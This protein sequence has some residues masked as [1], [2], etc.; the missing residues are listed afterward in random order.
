MSVRNQLLQVFDELPEREQKLLFHIALQFV[1]DDDIATA[2]D[3]AA[4]AEAMKEYEAGET[5][6][7]DQIDWD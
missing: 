7:H 4:H 6:P 5:I 3:L 1:P 2:D